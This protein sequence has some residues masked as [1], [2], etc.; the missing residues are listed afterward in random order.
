MSKNKK[1]NPKVKKMWVDALLSGKYQQTTGVLK[2]YDGYCCL[3]VLCDLHRKV[4]KK[5]GWDDS[6]SITPAYLGEEA[7][8]PKQVMKWANIEDDA[9][10]YGS[11]KYLAKDN[12]NGKSFKEIAKIIQKN[13]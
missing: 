11:K 9:G 8:L 5:K 13:F 12:D 3:G 2:D 4:T 7:S 10:A 6:C 1:M